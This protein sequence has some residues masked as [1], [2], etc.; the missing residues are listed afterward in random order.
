MKS[1]IINMLRKSEE[2]TMIINEKTRP[3]FNWMYQYCQNNSK[4]ISTYGIDN[5]MLRT[6]F[7]LITGEVIFVNFDEVSN[8]CVSMSLL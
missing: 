5:M 2:Q 3:A 6:K 4:E 1:I 7:K 8:K